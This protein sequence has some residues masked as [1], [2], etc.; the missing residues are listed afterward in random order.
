MFIFI[1]SFVYNPKIS[2][3]VINS[4]LESDTL[5]VQ[6]RNRSRIGNSLLDVQSTRIY[7]FENKNEYQQFAEYMWY[8]RSIKNLVTP[9]SEQ[10]LKLYFYIIIFIK[11]KCAQK[12]V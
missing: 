2:R 8:R 3:H 4:S 1:L 10:L 9:E 6:H 7:D 5:N 11:N 12:F